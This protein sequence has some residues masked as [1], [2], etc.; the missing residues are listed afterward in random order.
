MSRPATRT[1]ARTPARRCCSDENRGWRP[2]VEKPRCQMF[3]GSPFP[4][5]QQK[6]SHYPGESKV[7]GRIA[8]EMAG[9]WILWTG[10]WV[11]GDRGCRCPWAAASPCCSMARPQGPRSPWTARAPPTFP[12][13]RRRIR[14]QWEGR[15][16]REGNGARS[17]LVGM[18]REVQ[19]SASGP[20]DGEFRPPDV[21][22]S[23]SG[24]PDQEFR[25]P[26]VQNS[27]SGPPD[28]EFRP[29]CGGISVC[30]PGHSSSPTSFPRLLN[31]S[32]SLWAV[33][34]GSGCPQRTS[35]W[36]RESAEDGELGGFAME[37]AGLWILWTGWW[38]A[39]DRWC[40][41][42]RAAASPCCSMARPQGPRSPWTA[43]APPTFPQRRRRERY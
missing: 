31:S 28:Q 3:M 34:A 1:R 40:K 41:C 37:M 23:A 4:G 5:G 43:R 8:M 17:F 30:S 27:A 6:G 36:L 33:P 35:P 24:P 42:P 11:A 32:S 29:P 26:D 13:R 15:Q 10:W 12:Q 16:G 22:N 21:Q 18:P 39:G 7:G 14:R 19:N 20:P 25:P 2:S 38:V 9:L